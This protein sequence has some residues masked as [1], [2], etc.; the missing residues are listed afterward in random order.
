MKR[1]GDSAAY[2]VLIRRLP[3]C[4]SGAAAPSVPHHLLCAGGRGVGMKAEDRWAV[5]LTWAEHTH[6]VDCVHS[7]GA[8]A[9]F[10][11]FVQR[12]VP[13]V[14]ALATALWEAREGDFSRMV[15][16]ARGVL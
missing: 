15:L 4:V 2:L 14:R 13:D 1:P 9:E 11:W 10:E 12:G 6:S 3:S 7:V 16:I 5:P 8:K